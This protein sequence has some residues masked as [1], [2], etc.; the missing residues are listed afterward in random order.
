MFSKIRTSKS[1]EDFSADIKKLKNELKY[2]DVIV[3]G[4][5]AGLSAVAGFD[6]GG[7]RFRKYFSDFE[8]KYGFHDMNS[9][10]FYPYDTPD[11]YWVYWSRHIRINR[12]D[13]PV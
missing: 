2:A 4:A 5:G 12:Y 6:Y 3:I 13:C 8:T 7:E 1:T 10:G 11:E 9:G